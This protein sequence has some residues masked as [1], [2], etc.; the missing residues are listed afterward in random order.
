MAK[1]V[2]ALVGSDTLL[3][4]E[5]LSAILHELPKDTQR[6]DIDGE[7]AD[8]ASVL[9]ELRSFA[10][11]GSGK[12]IVVRDADDFVSRFRDQMEEYVK[13]PSDSTTLILRFSSLPS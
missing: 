9:D 2:Y 6:T 1:P 12:L 5:A 13:S 4:Q 8:L 10:L 11:F 7:T 3:H